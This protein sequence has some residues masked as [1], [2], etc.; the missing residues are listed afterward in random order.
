MASITQN[1]YLVAG[2]KYR[3]ALNVT[4][5]R[6]ATATLTYPAVDGASLTKTEIFTKNDSF[7]TVFIASDPMR[8]ADYSSIDQSQD[9]YISKIVFNGSDGATFNNLTLYDVDTIEKIEDLVNNDPTGVYDLDNF[10][11]FNLSPIGF[12]DEGLDTVGLYFDNNWDDEVEYSENDVVKFGFKNPSNGE[13]IIS[14]YLCV[15]DGSGNSPVLFSGGDALDNPTKWIK[16]LNIKPV[17]TVTYVDGDGSEEKGEGVFSTDNYSW[18]GREN[19]NIEGARRRNYSDLEVV[20][21]LKSRLNASLSFGDK[22]T[23]NFFKWLDGNSASTINLDMSDTYENTISTFSTS[24]IKKIRRYGVQD[25]STIDSLTYN[26]QR[27]YARW[28]I[29]TNTHSDKTINGA[30]TKEAFLSNYPTEYNSNSVFNKGIIGS[31][32]DG[33]TPSD[34]N[35]NDTSAISFSLSENAGTSFLAD[36]LPIFDITRVMPMYTNGKHNNITLDMGFKKYDF[37]VYSD[38][39]L[40]VENT[41]LITQYSRGERIVITTDNNSFSTVTIKE[42]EFDGTDTILHID[43]VLKVIVGNDYTRG[44]IVNGGVGRHHLAINTDLTSI[45]NEI[46]QSI[47]FVEALDSLEDAGYL[48]TEIVGDIKKYYYRPF[49]EA[50]VDTDTPSATTLDVINPS[51]DNIIYRFEVASGASLSALESF[52]TSN[53]QLLPKKLESTDTIYTLTHL[54]SVNYTLSSPTETDTYSFNDTDLTANSIID[55]IDDT[56]IDTYTDTITVSSAPANDSTIRFNITNNFTIDNITVTTDEIF[57]VANRTATTFQLVREVGGSVLNITSTGNGNIEILESQ[58]FNFDFGTTPPVI[59]SKVKFKIVNGFEFNAVEVLTDSVYYVSAVSGT[60]FSLSRSKYGKLLDITNVGSGS[61]EMV[62]LE[63]TETKLYDDG[64]YSPIREKK[65]FVHLPTEGVKD[66]QE[67]S[68]TVSLPVENYETL[69]SGELLHDGLSA[70]NYSNQPRVYIFSGRDESICSVNRY[71]YSEYFNSL[72]SE[73]WNDASGMVTTNNVYDGKS[74]SNTT[75]SVYPATTAPT[76]LSRT[77]GI[78]GNWRHV[79]G[80]KVELDLKIHDELYSNVSVASPSYISEFSIGHLNGKLYLEVTS[81][82]IDTVD[83][84]N[85]RLF[86]RVNDVAGTDF[87]IGEFNSHTALIGKHIYDFIYTTD[88]NV[89][90]GSGSIHKLYVTNTDTPDMTYTTSGTLDG[91]VV[92]FSMTNGE[93]QNDSAIALVE[94]E[95]YITCYKASSDSPFDGMVGGNTS[96]TEDNNTY[97]RGDNPEVEIYRNDNVFHQ[98]PMIASDI[99]FNDKR[100]LLASVYPTATNTFALKINENNNARLVYWSIL[101]CN[102]YE[103]SIMDASYRAI[104]S[105]YIAGLGASNSFGSGIFG[106]GLFGSGTTDIIDNYSSNGLL[107]DPDITSFPIAMKVNIASNAF[108]QNIAEYI[109]PLLPP[110]LLPTEYDIL[111]H[112]FFNEAYSNYTSYNY[113]AEVAWTKLINFMRG[114]RL[115]QGQYG[116]NVDPS[117]IDSDVGDCRVFID[118][119]GGSTGVTATDFADYLDNYYA[120]STYLETYTNGTGDNNTFVTWA[121]YP[122]YLSD[123]I[124]NSD[125][126]LDLSNIV[127]ITV[128]IGGT[129]SDLIYHYNEY[130]PTITGMEVNK[131]SFLEE[132]VSLAEIKNPNPSNK[133]E[134]GVFE[135]LTN[136][137]RYSISGVSVVNS[138]L[139]SALW[140]ISF[141]INPMQLGDATTGVNGGYDFYHSLDALFSPFMNVL[142]QDNLR[143]REVPNSTDFPVNV[144]TYISPDAIEKTN[145]GSNTPLYS[146]FL[147]MSSQ[148]PIMRNF[149]DTERTILSIFAKY[150]TVDSELVKEEYLKNYISPYANQMPLRTY[151]SFRLILEGDIDSLESKTSN[152]F[153]HSDVDSYTDWLGYNTDILGDQNFIIADRLLLVENNLE[154]LNTVNYNPTFVDVSLNKE[155]GSTWD[156]MYADLSLS[157]PP[158]IINPIL[159]NSKQGKSYIRVDMKFV[160][161]QELGRW[162]TLD[163]R[164]SP[165]SYLSPSFGAKAIDHKVTSYKIEGT[166]GDSPE[167]YTAA[168]IT[169]GYEMISPIVYENGVEITTSGVYIPGDELDIYY[170]GVKVLETVVLLEGSKTNSVIIADDIPYYNDY[171]YSKYRVLYRDQD[172]YTN[173]DTASDYLWIPEGDYTETAINRSITQRNQWAYLP[174]YRMTAMEMNKYCIPFISE[175]AYSN[176]RIASKH[177]SIEASDDSISPFRIWGLDTLHSFDIGV[178]SDVHGNVSS[179][180]AFSNP[181]PWKMY[182]NIRPCNT[183]S[184]VGDI[185]SPTSRTGGDLTDPVLANIYQFPKMDNLEY[186]IPWDQDHLI[187]WLR[188]SECKTQGTGTSYLIIDAEDSDTDRNDFVWYES[189]GDGIITIVNATTIVGDT[190]T[191]DGTDFVAGTDF[192]V[193]GLTDTATN[194]TTAINTAAISGVTASNLDSD[195]GTTNNI[196]LVVSDTSYTHTLEYT[197]SDP[198]EDAGARISE[199]YFGNGSTMEERVASTNIIIDASQRKDFRIEGDDSNLDGMI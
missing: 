164:Q 163:Y 44:S 99:D 90:G 185:P 195:T 10:G 151:N 174:Y 123:D 166:T 110:S 139:Q 65:T 180:S 89:S 118:V 26:R 49:N 120:D 171:I 106:T 97:M 30:N 1:V 116:N 112:P 149:Y 23:G 47:E 58:I 179:T 191:I 61:I 27:M 146:A 153:W 55:T 83:Y 126:A 135:P 167:D 173:G 29:G 121:T 45:D 87:T 130:S 71:N 9:E 88:F 82:T 181:L 69:P 131:D 31:T 189:N 125:S 141:P 3:L 190:I 19:L 66:G 192:V 94:Y 18:T 142:S 5:D 85:F 77:Y 101:G 24:N 39:I 155:D 137:N 16:M 98:S 194:L 143:L 182:W 100:V 40:T 84:C 51:D 169:N 38:S 188:D 162:I 36:S 168:V 46:N 75:G 175:I 43:K 184:L 74:I 154:E 129:A 161:S 138:A 22:D 104:Q 28:G 178:A 172:L 132:D 56:G 145:G 70:K 113:Q 15:A 156:Y 115:H 81:I 102:A 147:D 7:A 91:G 73:Y 48:L 32:T 183:T 193:S 42:V 41:N 8:G 50:V 111:S 34:S 152:K 35:L 13:W 109:R 124:K 150:A 177:S 25:N 134:F 158:V 11:T 14:Y 170:N 199:Y 67:C 122:L 96:L 95:Q 57:Y 159:F 92:N 144:G 52:I 187:D 93:L 133:G 63:Y 108:I 33:S 160:Y 37:V 176:G 80:I 12:P 54:T 79:L 186:R 197:Q 20:D 76:I 4:L 114:S 21:F 117:V 78:Y 60:A 62:G 17:F 107:N 157:K 198:S 105:A 119:V 72:N 64:D 68:L 196:H 165:T 148:Y 128:G 103:N 127:P 86:F 6:G 140:R 53:A 59:N 2:R 136:I